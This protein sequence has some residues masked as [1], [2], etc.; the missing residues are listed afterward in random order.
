VLDVGDIAPD[1]PIRLADGTTRSLSSYRGHP[2]ILYFF[3]KANT[4]GCTRETRGFSERYADFQRGGI[5]IIGVSV[6]SPETQAAFGEKCGSRFPLVGDPSKEIARKYGVLGLL[7]MAKRVTF[8]VDA[9]GRIRER[10]EGMLP[11]PHLEAAEGWA[12]RPTPP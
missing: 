1:F 12:A 2:V 7:G 5:E 8:L 9:N 6:D 11:G 3:P 4:T 10:V